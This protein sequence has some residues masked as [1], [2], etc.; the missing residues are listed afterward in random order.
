MVLCLELNDDGFYELPG[1]E[2]KDMYDRFARSDDDGWEFLGQFLFAFAA[3]GLLL[4]MVQ[5]TQP[6]FVDIETRYDE[7][8]GYGCTLIVWN[9]LMKAS[10]VFPFSRPRHTTLTT[11]AT[12]EAVRHVNRLLQTD[13]SRPITW[14][15]SL[16]RAVLPR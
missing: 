13:W 14:V 11:L 5:F 2:N 15:G 4:W 10:S 9:Y 16:S 1:R 8:V 7:A 6:Y 12:T 3:L